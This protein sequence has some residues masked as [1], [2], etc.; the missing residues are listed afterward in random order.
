MRYGKKNSFTI[1]YYINTYT[2]I[3]TNRSNIKLCYINYGNNIVIPHHLC[4]TNYSVQ[5]VYHVT[6]PILV[7][8]GTS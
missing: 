6:I 1:S 4:N 7:Y 8:T 5:P 2:N 3:Y